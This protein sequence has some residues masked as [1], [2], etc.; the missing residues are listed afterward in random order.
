MPLRLADL[1]KQL[2]ADTN[3][4][5]R[6]VGLSFVCPSCN[7]RDRAKNR[8]G[9]LRAYC[10]PCFNRK[11]KNRNHGSYTKRLPATNR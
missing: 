1:V 3:P 8:D 2:L 9:T 6:T 5:T 4:P 10:N 11:Y 7:L